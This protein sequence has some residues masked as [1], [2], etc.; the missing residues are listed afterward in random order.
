MTSSAP[1]PR[2]SSSRAH[3]LGHCRGVHAESARALD[4]DVLAQFEPGQLHAADDLRERA[5]HAGDHRVGQLVGHLE[6]GRARSNVVVVAECAIEVRWHVARVGQIRAR[7]R[8]GARDPLHARAT[9]AARVEVAPHHPIAH[10]QWLPGCV[11]RDFF[12]QLVHRAGHLVA[13]DLRI[14]SP[15]LGD[16]EFAAPLVQV[17]A[18]H[19]GDGHL[20]DDA[21][22]VRL[23]HLVFLDL[24]G[25]ARP[26]KRGHSSRCHR[27]HLTR[28]GRTS[29][30]GTPGWRPILTADPNQPC[31]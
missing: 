2:A 1:K 31:E 12:A 4:D 19:V 5:V 9:G 30:C 23:G 24:H 21:A 25:F 17:R 28:T 22:R 10:A 8:A 20:D 3:F 7:V 14:R 15:E 27:G 6:D 29:L 26:V 18:A 13:E 11:P 16:V